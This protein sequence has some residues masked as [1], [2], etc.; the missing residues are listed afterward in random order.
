MTKKYNCIIIDDEA[1]A[2]RLLSELISNI[3]YLHIS[4]TYDDPLKALSE[5]SLWNEVDILFLDIDMP[6]LSGIQLASKLSNNVKNI[7]FTTAYPQYALEA[8]GVYATDYL[9]KPI[10]AVRFIESVN[11][12]VGKYD[13]ALP[14]EQESNLVFIKG[15]LKGKYIRLNPDEIILIYTNEHYLQIVTHSKEYRTNET[16]KNIML[17]LKNDTRFIRIHQSNAINIEQIILV[18]GNTVLLKNNW[19]VPISE[20]YKKD[21]MSLINKKLLNPR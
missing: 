15:D 10:E 21:F 7:V 3:P 18:E 17:K 20:H 1:F 14:A 11:N 9:L 13:N 5:L 2:I 8:F 16:L 6:E 19:K 12:I 4:K